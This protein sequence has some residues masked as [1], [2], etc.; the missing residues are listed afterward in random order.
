[1]NAKHGLTG[2]LLL[3]A[4]S[5]AVASPEAC[6]PKIERAWVRAAPPGTAMM[7]GYLTLRNDCAKPVAIAGVESMDFGDAMIHE[8]IVENGV[9]KMRH[10]SELVMPAKS[11]LI[12]EPGGRHLMLMRPLR[13]L[14]AGSRVRIR[15]ILGDGR[16]LFAE[17]EVRREAPAR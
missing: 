6:A 11:K 15:L 3:L 8:T 13:A 5:A 17:Y 7:A 16:K 9:S 2:L 10:T 14:P 1:M 12:F 4:A